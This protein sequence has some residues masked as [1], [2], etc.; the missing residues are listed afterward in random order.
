MI[1]ALLEWVAGALLVS[2]T[3]AIVYGI[4]REARKTEKRNK[5]D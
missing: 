3:L 4:H 1:Y 5:H 2:A